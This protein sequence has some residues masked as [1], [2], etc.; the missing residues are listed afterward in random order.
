M[1]SK[2]DLKIREIDEKIRVQTQILKEL[3][4]IWNQLDR[5]VMGLKSDLERLNEE[6]IT[7]TQ[8]QMIFDGSANF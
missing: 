4:P 8:G 1:A 5:K 3:F 7:L 2:E 6:K